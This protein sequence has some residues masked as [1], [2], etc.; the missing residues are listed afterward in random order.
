MWKMFETSRFNSPKEKV[1]KVLRL[2][3][4]VGKDHFNASPCKDADENLRQPNNF[5]VQTYIIADQRKHEI[6]TQKA[7]VIALSRHER[8]KA[9]GFL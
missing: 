3:R 9:G 6:E 1:S 2:F 8:G 4:D 5:N 7:F